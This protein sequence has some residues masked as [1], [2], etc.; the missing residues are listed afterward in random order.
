MASV[1]ISIA[2]QFSRFPGGR[3]ASDGPASA[4]EFR[5]ALLVP[6]ICEA[7][8]SGERVTV[9]LD[10]T[11]GYAASFLEEAFGWLVRVDG[12][13]AERLREMMSVSSVDVPDYAAEAM[14]YVVEADD[15]RKGS[16]E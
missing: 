13:T 7:E 1:I 12:F 6:A 3:S 14:R 16:D 8:K 10:G 15:A 11:L 5:E 9:S 2:R 4:E